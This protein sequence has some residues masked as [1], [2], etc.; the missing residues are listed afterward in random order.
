MLYF[1]VYGTVCKGETLTQPPQFDRIARLLPAL[2]Q[3]AAT[4]AQR[5]AFDETDLQVLR[6]GMGI[7]DDWETSEL[8]RWVT[9]LTAAREPGRQEL[10]RRAL[11]MRGIPEEDANRA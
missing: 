7:D 3:I 10:S 1:R 2:D 8:G 9:I 4:I 6:L 5:G 11:V